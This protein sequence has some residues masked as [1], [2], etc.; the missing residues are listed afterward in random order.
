[1]LA[2]HDIHFRC[3]RAARRCTRSPVAT[4]T[5]KS[6]SID[7]VQSFESIHLFSA[8]FLRA[9]DKTNERVVA[10][11]KMRVDERTECVSVSLCATS[12]KWRRASLRADGT[13]TTVSPLKAFTQTMNQLAF[14]D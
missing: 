3:A 4:C 6:C 10:L 8:V 11:K 12:L 1:M 14:I 7:P 5:G 2:L 9:R 13:A